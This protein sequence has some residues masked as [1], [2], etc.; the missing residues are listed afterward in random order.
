MAVLLND[1]WH[2]VV[3]DSGCVNSSILWIKFKFLRVKVCVVVRYCPEEEDGEE[4]DID[5]TLDSVGNGYRIVYSG[6]AKWIDKR[7]AD[8]TGAFGVAG[9]NDNGKRV[10]DF[11]EESGLCMG[12]T[13]FNH[14]SMYK[15]TRVVKGPRWVGY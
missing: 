1:V 6:R 15:Y 13:Y 4:R 8:I 3:V 2:R 9:E 10:V 5:R 11:C 7:K 14:R 12:K